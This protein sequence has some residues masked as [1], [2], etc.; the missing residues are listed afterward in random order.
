MFIYY[1]LFPTWA[2]LTIFGVSSLV[3]HS[4]PA[5]FLWLSLSFASLFSLSLTL[6]ALIVT[7]A[8]VNDFFILLF[9]IKLHAIILCGILRLQWISKLLPFLWLFSLHSEYNFLSHMRHILLL[10][11]FLKFSCLFWC[12]ICL[13]G[14]HS[15]CVFIV[16]C[17]PSRERAT[18]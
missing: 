13:L 3:R 18:K 15:A 11:W 1:I 14:F 12:S 8:V 17:V 4:R 5:L 2:L 16:T 6:G 10:S 9:T 7:F